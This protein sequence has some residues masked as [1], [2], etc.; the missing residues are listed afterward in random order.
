M[1]AIDQDR[2]RRYESAAGLANDLRRYLASE[3]IQARPPSTRYRVAKFVQRHRLGV[4]AAGLIAAAITTGTVMTA[5]GF[6][7]ASR[8]E[9]EAERE[10]SAAREVT[11]FLVDLFR[12]SDPDESRGNTLTARELLDQA[13]ARG[14]LPRD[15]YLRKRDDLAGH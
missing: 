13:Y 6:V 1:K 9:R 7:R 15:E 2:S 10:A 8:A 14:E 5:V 11:S 3:P 12:V 4:A